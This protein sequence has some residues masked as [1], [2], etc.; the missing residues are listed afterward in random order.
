VIPLGKHRRE[1]PKAQSRVTPTFILML[2]LFFLAAVGRGQSVAARSRPGTG[3]DQQ[4]P[5]T[6][7]APIVQNGGTWRTYTT[8]D[9]LANNDVRAV[10]LDGAGHLWF[11][12]Y[13]GG[14]SEFD[15]DRWRTYTTADGLT[16]NKVGAIAIDGNG[17]MWFGTSGGGVSEFDGSNWT[18]YTTINSDLAD[19][20]VYAIAIDGK[21]HKWFGTTSGVSEFDGTTWT[22]YTTADG[23]PYNWVS[24][25]AIDKAGHKWFGTKAGLSE[26]DGATWTTHKTYEVYAIAIDG[27][28]HM[29]FGTEYG[30][31]E[32]DG[33]TW[34]TY[35]PAVGLAS[36]LVTAVAIDGTGSKWFGTY[37]KGV[38]EF[39]GHTW[40]TY[41]TLDGLADNQVHAIAV[42]GVGHI[43]FGTSGGVS[44]FIAPIRTFLPL[45]LWK[46]GAYFTGPWELEPNNSYDEANGPLRSGVDYY[47]YPND[48]KDYF[49]IE[50]KATGNVSVDLTNH[51]GQN[52][53]VQLFYQ[54][55][56]SPVAW[57][58]DAPYHIE[59]TGPAGT[60]YIYINTGSGYNST[61]PYTLRVTFP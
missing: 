41:T 43:W 29:W 4:R 44:E 60:Y 61:T 39:D 45:I 12:T 38:S 20:W 53:Q 16:N 17:H 47:G 35:S 57:D 8:A 22:T 9:G 30:V 50:T 40:T 23:L 34:K 52:V 51:T 2:A 55:V 21:G 54:S 26:F 48:E 32:F 42:D 37:S 27:A 59:H 15:G 24:A 19:N 7:V 36:N 6:E 3:L 49:S 1:Q 5:E 10:A 11:G 28:G 13:G 14:V 58:L 31:S 18:S 46:H 25:I 33:T 56:D